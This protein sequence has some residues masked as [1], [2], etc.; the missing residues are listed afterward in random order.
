ML[1][2]SNAPAARHGVVVQINVGGV[3]PL[4]FASCSIDRDN[5]IKG[6]AN[7]EVVAS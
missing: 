7:Y 3:T 1:P 6:C 5:P 2:L 4:L